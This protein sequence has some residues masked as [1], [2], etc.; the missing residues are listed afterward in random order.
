MSERLQ[1]RNRKGTLV[2]SSKLCLPWVLSL[3]TA[4][5]VGCATMGLGG[6]P[7]AGVSRAEIDTAAQNGDFAFLRG[8]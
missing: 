7:A 8:L 4:F 6:K 1:A 2:I 5:V 3:T